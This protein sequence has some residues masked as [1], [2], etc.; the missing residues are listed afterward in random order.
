VFQ[1]FVLINETICLKSAANRGLKIK[2]RSVIFGPKAIS[3]TYRFIDHYL[4]FLQSYFHVLHNFNFSKS[5]VD[6]S[7]KSLRAR[8]KEKLRTKS[9]LINLKDKRRNLQFQKNAYPKLSKC[10]TYAKKLPRD[11]KKLDHQDIVNLLNGRLETRANMT[12]EVYV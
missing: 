12:K 2:K 5:L 1:V 10:W 3:K 11:I 6:G 8:V 7:R 4:K 9:E